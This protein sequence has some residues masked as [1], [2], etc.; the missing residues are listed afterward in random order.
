MKS[1]VKLSG[2]GEQEQ[3]TLTI[4]AV[5]LDPLVFRDHVGL[6]V[7]EAV[8]LSGS[9]ESQGERV[10]FDLQADLLD[11]QSFSGS[12]EQDL[13]KEKVDLRSI[14]LTPMQRSGAIRVRCR[15]GFEWLPSPLGAPAFVLG[16]SSFEVYEQPFSSMDVRG[17]LQDSGLAIENWVATTAERK[18]SLRG[19]ST[20]AVSMVS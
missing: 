10:D 16:L 6:E 5:R 17:H 14:D 2:R 9:V 20:Q 11:G 18:A 15:E 19:M 4:E 13:S 3:S 8:D 1:F 12:K 7:Q